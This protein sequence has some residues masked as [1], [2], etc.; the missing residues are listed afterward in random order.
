MPNFTGVIAMPRFTTVL[1]ALNRSIS[2]RRSPVAA[3]RL[4]AIGD[5]VQE[6][7]RHGHAVR[8]HVALGHA[9]EVVPAHVER[10]AAEVTRDV[11]HHRLDHHH[12]LRPAEAAKRGVGDGMRLAAVRDDLDVLQEIGVVD[13]A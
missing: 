2:R 9:V 11:V 4:E 6:V 3:A 8:R 5:D 1:V 13:V 10:I 12:A 7:V